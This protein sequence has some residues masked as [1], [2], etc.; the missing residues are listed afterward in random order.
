MKSVFF[1]FFNFNSIS[2]VC[3]KLYLVRVIKTQNIAQLNVAFVT[4]DGVTLTNSLD[5]VITE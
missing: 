1:F 3:S 5:Q 2:L 4:L